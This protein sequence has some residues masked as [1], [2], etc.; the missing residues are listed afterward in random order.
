MWCVPTI[1]V[2]LKSGTD[3][4]SSGCEIHE[5]REPSGSWWKDIQFTSIGGYHANPC[6]A[7]YHA[8]KF[9]KRFGSNHLQL[10]KPNISALEG[11]TESLR[12][13][14]VPEWNIAA[15]IV[16][17]GGFQ[18]AWNGDSMVEYPAPAQ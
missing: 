8:G 14:M 11:F 10:F 9:R 12:K 2:L 3:R 7:F 17:P 16:Q 6:L 4:C 1:Y 13:E 18:T 15:T 5:R